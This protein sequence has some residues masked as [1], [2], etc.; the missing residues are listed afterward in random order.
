MA[1]SGGGGVFSGGGERDDTGT[2]KNHQ[3]EVHDSKSSYASKVTGSKKITRE[4]LNVL[5]VFL[6]RKDD[7][8]SFNLSKEELAKLVFRKMG[9]APKSVK[10]ID[11]SGFGKINIELEPNV[12]LEPMINLPLF[13]IRD[14][15]RTKFYRPHHRKDTLVTISWLD[16]ETPD[17]LVA[18]VMS[19]FGNLK[20]NIQWVK[21]KKEEN[22]SELASMLNNIL[23]G[24]RQVWMEVNK[25]IPSYGVIDGKKVKM[26]H[27]G[28][29]RTCAR[30]QK[31]ADHCLGNSNAKLCDERGGDKV[32][33]D[34][35]WKDILAD[36]GYKAW[37]DDKE[38]LVEEDENKG[39][40]S[41]Q[42]ELTEKIVSTDFPSCDGIVV[43]NLPEDITNEAIEKMVE[44]VGLSCTNQI[45]ILPAGSSR[46]RLIKTNDKNLIS[47]LVVKMNNK[48][49]QGRMLH[50][51]PHVPVTPPKPI[52]DQEVVISIA[53]SETEAVATKSENSVT[54]AVNINSKIGVTEATLKESNA[55]PGLTEAEMI[56]AKKSAEKRKKNAAAK[57]RRRKKR[58]EQLSNDRNNKLV[59]EDFLEAPV[60]ETLSVAAII[61]KFDFSEY[62]S[63]ESDSDVFEDSKDDITGELHAPLVT[64]NTGHAQNSKGSKRSI[65]SPGQEGVPKKQK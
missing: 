26:Y 57:E 12:N 48:S 52:N 28:Q 61:Q 13:E 33:V 22:E 16:I 44:K 31:T 1:T 42:S 21:F 18:H 4:K 55:I 7:S 11:T 30:C 8:V 9:I 62:S 20:S 51:Q 59:K 40:N 27:P 10:K 24:E 34:N 56:K 65:S 36:V 23:S 46:C 54:E 53:E 39:V 49:F 47:E 2:H 25:P 29:R 45:S 38:I 17:S 32:G 3:G 63:D 43:A 6:E 58:E 64:S 14:G 41:L 19:H 5:D 50:C 35:V 37:M 60:G 15:L